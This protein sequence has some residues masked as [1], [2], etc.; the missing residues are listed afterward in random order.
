MGDWFS[1]TVTSWSGSDNQWTMQAFLTFAAT[2]KE[3]ASW[4]GEFLKELRGFL[5]GLYELGFNRSRVF[6][7]FERAF[8]HE[9]LGEAWYVRVEVRSVLE[10]WW[11][12]EFNRS[13]VSYVAAW[14]CGAQRWSLASVCWFCYSSILQRDVYR[15]C[16]GCSV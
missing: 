8:E 6:W 3:A 10:A 7:V 16:V 13:S 15:L 12:R 14:G 9:V 4:L 1:I 2:C 5:K 11:V